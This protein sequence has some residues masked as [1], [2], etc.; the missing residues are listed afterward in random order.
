MA[1]GISGVTV[2]RK[3]TDKDSTSVPTLHTGAPRMTP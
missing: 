1:K 3:A 2:A